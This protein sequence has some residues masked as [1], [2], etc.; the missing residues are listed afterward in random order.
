MEGEVKN[1][2]VI[3]VVEDFHTESLHQAIAPLVLW[4]A[5][6]A[7]IASVRIA[8]SDADGVLDHLRATWE[9]F[10]TT[11]PFEYSFVND[12]FARAYR[13]ERRMMQLLGGFA[14]L[15]ILVACLGLLGL[16]AYAARRREKEV[17]IRKALGT[18]VI[19]IVGLLSKDYLRL[20]IVA[21][22]LAVPVAYWAS[23]KWL[24]AFA[25]RIDL[26]PSLFVGAGAL[27]LLVALA[28]VSTQALR[29]VRIDPATT[30]RDG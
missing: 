5:P 25:Y 4:M 12:Q 11:H 3:G 23:Q 15:A 17:G 10:E 24:Q 16:A 27:V 21:F 20:V 1:G 18:T 7:N 2:I 8:G 14:G 13:T 30:L 22:V 29:A 19:Q 9:S 6:R 26:G 28:T